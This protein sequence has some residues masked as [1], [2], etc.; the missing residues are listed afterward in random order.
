MVRPVLPDETPTA[1]SLAALAKLENAC[2]RCP[3]YRNAT[4]AV[5]GEG[6]RGAAVMLVGEQPGDKEDL[7]G[8]PFVGPA[9]RLLDEALAEAGIARD[10]AFVTNAV[11]HFKHEMRGKRRLHQKPNAGEIERCRWW[12]EQERALVRPAVIVALGLTAAR[13][14]FGR[15]MPIGKSRGTKHMLEGGTPAFVTIHPSAL[16][17]I[18][19]RADKEREYRGFVGDLR[20]VAA[21]LRRQ[22]A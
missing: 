3:L 12:L 4:Q 9:G 20:Q 8:R 19:E 14:V 21:L 6:A 1:A 17:R 15:P 22:A 10:A 13:S 16:L 11:K 5:A 7:A 18:R 2:Q